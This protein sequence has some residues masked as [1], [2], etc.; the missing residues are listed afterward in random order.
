MDKMNYNLV[1]IF[2]NNTQEIARGK[3]AQKFEGDMLQSHK[4][5]YLEGKKSPVIAHMIF[6][7]EFK[8]GNKK[9]GS[10]NGSKK[11][12]AVINLLDK[13][14]EVSNDFKDFVASW[15]EKYP[16]NGD[17]KRFL[18]ENDYVVFDKVKKTSK[19]KKFLFKQFLKTL[20]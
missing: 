9:F 20:K 18:V 14:E 2:A 10:S 6:R 8:K 4:N 11:A 1:R 12:I 5:Y 15:K 19:F 16:K 17:I 3:K 7:D 13:A